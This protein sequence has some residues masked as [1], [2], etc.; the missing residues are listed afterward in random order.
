MT[1]YKRSM[2]C[3]ATATGAI[4]PAEQGAAE[5]FFNSLAREWAGC[6]LR[7]VDHG[8]DLEMPVAPLSGVLRVKVVHRSCAGRHG[9]RLPVRFCPN[10]GAERP[11]AWPT[12]VAAVA[13]ALAAERQL[14]PATMRRFV[15]RVLESTDT[16][17]AMLPNH[18]GPDTAV[19]DFLTAERALVLGHSL[20]PAPRS[21]AELRPERHRFLPGLSPGFRLHWAFVRLDA[22][23]C[24]DVG[25]RT[26]D[27]L[28]QNLGAPRE[29]GWLTLPMHPW[30][31]RHLASLPAVEALRRAGAVRFLAEEAG[32]VWHP[33]ASV[34]SLYSA[35]LPW[36][37]KT[38]LGARI[39]NSVRTLFPAELQRG[40][41]VSRL[42]R[43]ALGP[44][45]AS[46]APHLT[47]LEEPAYFGL[48]Y[49]GELLPDSLV[50][51]RDNPFCGG[52]ARDAAML[53][54]LC[55]TD[56]ETGR[57]P[58]AGLVATAAASTGLSLREAGLHW[59]RR[60]A[61][62]LPLALTRLRCHHGLLFGA[63]GQN[64]VLRLRRGWP[65]QA[66][67]RDCQGSGHVE[68]AHARLAVAVPDIGEQAEAIVPDTVGNRLLGYYVVVNGLFGLVAALSRDGLAEEEAM[69]RLLRTQLEC[70][71]A[72]HPPDPSFLE[73]ILDSPAL[74]AK[75][76]FMTFLEDV[77]ENRGTREQRAIYHD[78]PNPLCVQVTA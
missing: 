1:Y 12:A 61:E 37:L 47:F 2:I 54:T 29:P 32:A 7:P 71:R 73:Y 59:L 41:D 27:A 53:A 31:A 8:W 36:M 34:R 64:A 17:E 10:G 78:L 74:A 33:T 57:T 49:E 75:G 26:A 65:V 42:L 25:D 67:V 43:S 3:E 28:L 24:E 63:H 13:E 62:L 56:P 16:I 69:F 20:H 70:V 48:R 58:L 38:S 30:Q 15:D 23:A 39:T 6:R 45:I 66:Y 5:A 72:T 52:G 22:F 68:S 60:F 9:L 55:Q 18:A 50:V 76:N 77:I 4:G 40:K 35:E 46:F 11:M 19:T 14:A 21:A 51:L 44:E